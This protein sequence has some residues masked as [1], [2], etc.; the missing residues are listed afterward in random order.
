MVL[1]NQLLTPVGTWRKGRFNCPMARYCLYRA[2][3]HAR[4]YFSIAIQSPAADGMTL[5]QNPRG[6][7]YDFPTE[8]AIHSTLHFFPTTDK[9]KVCWI[10]RSRC[11]SGLLAPKLPPGPGPEPHSKL[12]AF[13]VSWCRS[14][15]Y[16]LLWSVLSPEGKEANK[17]FYFFVVG[18]AQ[19]FTM[20]ISCIPLTIR[21]PNFT[22]VTGLS[23]S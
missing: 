7:D 10:T 18:A 16:C 19:S 14:Q 15:H 23:V 3:W 4:S 1:E 5:L 9:T 21:S 17:M 13:Y 12:A 6:L 11:Q 20:V 2:Q 8:L 22:Q